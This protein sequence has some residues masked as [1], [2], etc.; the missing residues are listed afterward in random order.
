MAA[1]LNETTFEE[2]LTQCGQHSKYEVAIVLPHRNDIRVFTEE[3]IRLNSLDRIPFFRDVRSTPYTSVV[4]F[5]NGSSIEFTTV[6]AMRSG[7]RY[8]TVLVH[9]EVSDPAFLDCVARFEKPYE[10]DVLRDAMYAWQEDYL[11]RERDLYKTYGLGKWGFD[12]EPPIDPMEN[13]TDTEEL[14]SFLNEFAV[15]S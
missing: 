3:M 5:T 1:Y 13:V 11:R 4:R 14:D 2:I 8:H 7:D 12:P 15:K 9:D 10:G 6:S